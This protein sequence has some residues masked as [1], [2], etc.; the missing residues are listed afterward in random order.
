MGTSYCTG[1]YWPSLIEQRPDHCVGYTW[2]YGTFIFFTSILFQCILFMTLGLCVFVFV[3]L[4]LWSKYFLFLSYARKHTDMITTL[5][6][7]T[8]NTKQICVIQ[9]HPTSNCLWSTATKKKKKR[10]CLKTCNVLLSLDCQAKLGHIPR[11][12]T[13]RWKGFREARW[14]KGCT[15]LGVSCLPA[16]NGLCFKRV[17]Q[18]VG[19]SGTLRCFTQLFYHQHPFHKSVSD[20]HLKNLRTCFSHVSC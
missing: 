15:P 4:F 19:P 1:N 10:F 13:R 18:S 7:H 14:Q 2:V 11:Q 6:T 3:F 12:P 20:Y 8:H 5:R 17:W 16:N 9:T